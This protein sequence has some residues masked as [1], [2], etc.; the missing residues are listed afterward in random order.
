LRTKAWFF[1]ISL[2]L[3]L[4]IISH[5]YAPTIGSSDF[6]RY[7]S[8]SRLLITGGNPYDGESLRTLQRV[9]C[10]GLRIYE[11]DVA[12]T[13]NPPWLL[14]IMIPLAILP[15]YLAVRLWIILNIFLTIMPLLAVWRMAMKSR[16]QSLFPLV[17][18]AG[19]LFGNTLILIQMGQISSL[20]LTLLILSIFL[21]QKE[22]DWLSGATLF[23]T[24]IKPHLVFLVLLVVLV[25]SIRERRFK[26]LAGM[27]ITCLL[28]FFIAGIFFP[29]LLTLYKKN[30]FHLPYF[31]IYS[32]TLGSFISSFMGIK[33]F[34]YVGV[35]LLPL[36]FPLSRLISKEGWLTTINL[37]LLIS[38]PLSP[39]G[40]CFDHVLFLPA[41]IEM[42]TWIIK[43]ELPISVAWGTGTGIMVTYGILFWMMTIRGLPYYWFFWIA[44]A[45]LIIYVMAWRYHHGGSQEAGFER[46][47]SC[48]ER[49]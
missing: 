9:N 12:E 18:G 2:G 37:A 38:I 30:I 7:W 34:H 17:L 31:E 14:L 6:I 39:Y 45:L 35:L 16:Y 23:L 41:V 22:K 25:W 29:D 4:A 1:I 33:V 42:I 24:T 10:P 11:K 21:I 44:F 47:H 5:V 40:F 36:A 3:I 46:N 48:F 26:I 19:V 27:I 49:S 28:S 13:W 20:I 8:A 15:F 32:S 43:R